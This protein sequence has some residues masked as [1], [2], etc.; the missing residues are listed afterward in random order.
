[1][2]FSGATL[3]MACPMA[4]AMHSMAYPDA[5]RVAFRSLSIGCSSDMIAFREVCLL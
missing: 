1:M 3:E 5:A 2:R 4:S